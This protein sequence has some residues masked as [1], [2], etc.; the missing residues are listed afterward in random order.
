MAIYKI[1]AICLNTFITYPTRDRIITLESGEQSTVTE[2]FEDTESDSAK[3][4]A[5]L[6]SQ[7]IEYNWLNYAD[8]A[9]HVEVFPPL[10]TWSFEDGMHLFNEF[11]FL[12]FTKCDDELPL[13][14]WPRCVIQGYEAIKNSNIA[15]L[16]A[17]GRR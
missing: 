11:P 4:K 17:L 3:A 8:P 16:Y 7:G 10:N 1:D 13:D 12:F 9:Q 15:Q 14:Q 6:D 2:S 5:F